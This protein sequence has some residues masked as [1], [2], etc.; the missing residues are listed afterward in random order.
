M[1]TVIVPGQYRAA[2]LPERYRAYA[3]AGFDRKYWDVV[4]DE[5]G[6]SF[7]AY[8][9]GQQTFEEPEEVHCCRRCKKP[10]KRAYTYCYR[11]SQYL[12]VKASI[13]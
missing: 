9:A 5:D 4:S 2:D 10:C 13:A 12:K 11:C 8:L 3:P 1:T 7:T 6:E